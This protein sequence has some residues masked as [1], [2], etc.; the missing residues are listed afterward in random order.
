M[1]Q[2]IPFEPSYRDDTIFCLLCAKD[3]LGRKPRLNEDVLNI[4][5]N[6]FERG[7]M[8]WIAVDDR[9]RVIGMIGTNIIC[10]TDMWL[11]RLYIKP[12]MKRN[13]L[14]SALLS[15][16]EDFARSKGIKTIHTRFGDDY[17]EASKFY[18]AKGFV[19]SQ[20][21]NGLRHFI[22]TVG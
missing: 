14:G 1:H 11:K 2:I 16:A 13:G 22:K 6:Y 18:P 21:S 10:E 19:E 5:Q 7:D 17:L 9:D 8:F 15:M 20:R 4:E 12:T 3:A